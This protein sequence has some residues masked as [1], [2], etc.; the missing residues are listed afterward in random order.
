MAVSFDN[1]ASGSGYPPSG[2]SFSHSLGQG[3]GNG[4]IVLVG[5][6]TIGGTG[7][8]I[9]S[10]TY[11]GSA[12][13]LLHEVSET[14]FSRETW[15]RVYYM[16]DTSLP[17]SAGSSTVSVS[18][19][20]GA[21]FGIVSAVSYNG[22]EQSAPPYASSSDGNGG[23]TGEYSTGITVA[24]SVGRLVDFGG[25]DDS[26]GSVTS[27]APSSGQTERGDYAYNDNFLVISDK[28]YTASG[29]N[30]MGQT[31]DAG[32]AGYGHIVVEL[33]DPTGTGGGDIGLLGSQ[34]YS[35]TSGTSVSGSYTCHSG[36]NRKLLVAAGGEYIAGGL[37]TNSVT[38]NGVALTKI[39]EA[40]HSTPYNNMAWFYLDEAS[41]P[42]TPGAYTLT[43]N[44][45]GTANPGHMM[46]IELSDASQ[47]A[48]AAY[49]SSEAS[50][51][52]SINTTIST[53]ETD[54]WIIGAEI[55]GND[56]YHEPTSGQT[57]LIDQYGGGGGCSA[58][59]GYELIA[60][61][62]STNMSWSTT[63]STNRMLQALL[64]IAPYGSTG[65]GAEE[66]S[67]MMGFSF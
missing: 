54:S 36:S 24:S 5:I 27:Q 44:F 62:G 25:V 67:V 58:C 63:P 47:G 30:S 49:N 48:P 43:A 41:F 37:N 12:M 16:L 19:S 1:I 53:T 35:T 7:N 2:I 3:S 40:D 57:E 21:Y 18:F 65:G 28:A 31:P 15:M 17:G 32:Y 61:A 23:L 9:S 20:G 10:C 4:R 29:S 56:Q 42:G 66:N 13:T 38:Y 46:V 51:A 22:V 33:E 50:S 6:T 45:S 11:N 52:T 60:A 14:Y 55:Q 26:G 34:G 39:M 59:L 8:T 64:A